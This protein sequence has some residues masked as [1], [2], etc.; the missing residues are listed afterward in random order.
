MIEGGE[1]R[2]EKNDFTLSAGS[3]ASILPM[4]GMV[5]GVDIRMTEKDFCSLTGK[6]FYGVSLS[7][8]ENMPPRPLGGASVFA[9]RMN[10]LWLCF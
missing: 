6:H 8:S 2:E 9:W 10:F 3:L 1:F 5:L 7:V 4:H